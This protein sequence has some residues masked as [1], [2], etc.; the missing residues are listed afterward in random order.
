[1]I[2]LKMADQGRADFLLPAVS[3]ERP[4]VKGAHIKLIEYGECS[5]IS[6]FRIKCHMIVT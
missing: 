6:G 1:M 2:A 3:V 5:W 4:I